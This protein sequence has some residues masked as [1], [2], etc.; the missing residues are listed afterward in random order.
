MQV[1]ILF[2]ISQASLLCVIAFT[3]AYKGICVGN[4]CVSPGSQAGVA[5]KE[6]FKS[7]TLAASLNSKDLQCHWMYHSCL[8]NRHVVQLYLTIPVYSRSIQH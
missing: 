3:A 8:N 2:E 1:M 5:A 6:D 4:A 7:N